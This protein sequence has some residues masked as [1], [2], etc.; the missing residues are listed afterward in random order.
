M[1]RPPFKN[2]IVS[3][4]IYALDSENMMPGRQ[5]PAAIGKGKPYFN[6]SWGNS[7]G[8]LVFVNGIRDLKAVTRENSITIFR[9]DA[10]NSPY[11]G[12]PK[13]AQVK[14][15][16]PGQSITP[17]NETGTVAPAFQY[18]VLIRNSKALEPLGE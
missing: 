15:L 5:V 18:V 12:S 9:L 2:K 8:P 13:L 17:D 11:P 10:K 1:N 6:T 3:L 4:N 7:N 14:V 16:I